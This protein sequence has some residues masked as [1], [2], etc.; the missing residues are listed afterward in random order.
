MP[1]RE[2]YDALIAHVKE[3]AVLGSCGAVL[4][5]DRET[6]MP[7]GGT[8]NRAEQMA[9]ISRLVH[10]RMTDPRIGEW[11]A[12]C[13][14]TELTADS[15]SVEAVN[16]REIQRDYD[17]STKV[18]SRLVEE[19]S[20]ASTM[21]HQAWVKARAAS[22]FA[23][24]APHLKKL[25]GLRREYAEAIGYDAVIYDALLDD[26]EPGASTKEV[27]E[28]FGA[29]RKDLVP[30]I[31][32][33]V[34]APKQPD[35][36]LLK[37]TFPVERQRVFCE[38]AASAIGFDFSRGLLGTVVHPF[39]I[40]IG[41]GDTRI[42]T[43]WEEDNFGVAFFSVLHEAGHGLYE[44]GLPAEHD[45]TP[46]AE[47]V[48]LSIHE[49]Q[50]RMWENFV[51]RSPAFWQ[52]F[53]PHARGIFGDLREAPQDGFVHAINRV[54]PSL[55]RVE[56]DE[57][58]YNLHII[59]RFEIEQALMSG[60]LNVD[61]VPAAWNEKFK[62][63]LGL[64]VPDDAHGVLQDVHWSFAGFGYFPTYALG[65]LSAAQ[66]FAA[67]R[68]A[69]PDLDERFARGEFGELLQWLRDNIHSQGKRFRAPDLLQ[70]VT[71]EKLNH[72]HLI[73]YLERR[74]QP[75]YDF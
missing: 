67:A 62:E 25:V 42:N 6:H 52:Y 24:F 69:I 7:E 43:R 63:L 74:Y 14:G 65:N 54:S 58:T 45:G 60:D 33:I 40:T 47:T 4:S 30:L 3:A 20:R 53:L 48:S 37:G 13:Q 57:A 73:E 68:K 5:W 44:Q 32:K 70:E 22:D 21:A 2:A 10:E 46:M 19:T 64:D 23:T 35:P 17:K 38:M 71:G 36:S 72:R 39:C 56:A 18:P 55:I 29:L 1:A 34:N 8:A 59:L 41:T 12:A 66:F 11:L 31:Q 15:R 75:L 16:L 27:A 26:F 28:V 51:G 50:S 61:A 9:L 49:S